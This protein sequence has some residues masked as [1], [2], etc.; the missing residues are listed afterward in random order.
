[1]TKKAHKDPIVWF[2]EIFEKAAATGMEDPNAMVVS[3]VDAEGAPSSRVVLLK[4]YDD[5]GFVFYTNYESQKGQEILANPQVC[6]NFYWRELGQQ[7]RI[8]GRAEPVREDEADAYFATRSRT[9]RLGAWASQQS[10]PLTNR[11][12]LMARVAKFEAKFLGGPVPRPPHWSGFRVVPSSFEFWTAGAFR[13]HDRRVF[14]KSEGI[15]VSH[16][17]FP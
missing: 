2:R 11:A 6:L 1:M 4:D 9:S 7:V 13:L 8:R 10:R 3:S 14:E 5:S 17:L 16:R 15:W 12:Q